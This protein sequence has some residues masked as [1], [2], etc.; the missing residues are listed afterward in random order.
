MREVLGINAEAQRTQSFFRKGPFLSS[1]RRRPEA[2]ALNRLDSGLRRNDALLVE[3]RV[4][5]RVMHCLY[6][7]WLAA[8]HSI[9]ISLHPLRLRIFVLD[10]QTSQGALA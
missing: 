6:S 5:E 9:G 8:V 10:F 4:S 1:S 3:W 7:L 2:S